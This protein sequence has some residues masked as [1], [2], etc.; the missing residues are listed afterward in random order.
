MADNSEL[1]E[2]DLVQLSLLRDFETDE[3]ID[4]GFL[5]EDEKLA[6]PLDKELTFRYEELSLRITAGIS[7]PATSVSWAVDNHMLPI[8]VVDDLRVELRQIA[9]TAAATNNISRWKRREEECKF[10]IF[11]PIMVV[12]EFVKK[13]A[14][15][16]EPWR[17]KMAPKDPVER[18]L[19]FE[20]KRARSILT[21]S[22]IAYQYLQQTPQQICSQIPSEYRVLHVEEIIRND[23][24]RKFHNKRERMRTELLKQ[25]HGELRA[26]VPPQLHHKKRKEVFVEHLLEPRVT[27]HGTARQFVPS[28]VRYGFLQPGKKNPGTGQAHEVRCGATYGRGIYSSPNADFSL[29]YTGDTCHATKANEFFGIKL[30]VC[31]TVMGRRVEM[32]REDNWRDQSQPFPGADSHVAN[33]DLE[34]IVFDAAQILPVYVIHID[35]GHDNALHFE[36]LPSD[37]G[38]F[39][40]AQTRRHPRLIEHIRWP[41]EAQRA[42]KAALARAAKYF[43]YGYGPATG[44]RF[45]VE[46]VGEA[47][48]DEEDY[49]EYQA[50]RGEE[51][52]DKT[53]LDFWSW[54]KAGEEMDAAAAR[55]DDEV[56]DLNEYFKE[57]IWRHFDRSAP[58]WDAIP[59][60]RKNDDEV[61]GD[62]DGGGFGLD[63]LMI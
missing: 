23:L 19:P 11:E 9:E 63:R 5:S 36:N 7:Y 52:R 3:L 37:P 16:L 61:E 50:L 35:W 57:R 12:L 21:S 28:I 53:N 59:D 14:A 15:R 4:G 22:A 41:G 18:D 20:E 54:V 40:P 62:D 38:R 43:P 39:V 26:Q 56:D 33:R 17:Q 45:V 49:G 32:T 58:D 2:D 29:S 60:P 8:K 44:G 47:D 48:E 42:K 31:A 34:Y 46:E 24:A 27:F 55:R 25:P 30:F 13:T 1:S 51:V 10:G 6:A